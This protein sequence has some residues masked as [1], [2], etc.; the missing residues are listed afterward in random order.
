M[1]KFFKSGLDFLLF[2]NLF[3]AICAVAQG[4]LTFKLIGSKPVYPVLALL[5]FSTIGIYNFSI[6]LIKPKYPENSPF[7]RV[8]WIFSHYRLMITFTVVAALSIIPLFLL[9]SLSAKTL[10]IFLGIFSLSYGLPL[11]SVNG[12]KFGLR[13]LPGLKLFLIAFVWASSCVLLPVLEAENLGFTAVSTQDTLLL[14][15]KRFLFVAA[16]TIPFDIRDLFQ[17]HKASLK[18]IPVVLG[19]KKAYLFCQFLLIIYLIFLFLFGRNGFDL[20]FWAL[21]F[22]VAITGWL[23]FRARIEKNEY[24]Y[25]FYLD[26][27][28]LLQYL[29]LLCCER[30]FA[31]I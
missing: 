16:I 14:L 4:L 13:N 17:D 11:F 31:F 21:A 26:G 22:T 12:E 20:T 10:L 2:S 5:F 6:L 30:V 27:T 24:Y 29:I 25:F 28:L 8:R 3:I 1:R 23:I 9:L 7:R 18:T 19:K 15:S